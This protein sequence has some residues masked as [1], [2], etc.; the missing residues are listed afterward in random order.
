MTHPLL[1]RVRSL[2]NPIG[3]LD[4]R[5]AT[6]WRRLIRRH[7][8]L[9]ALAVNT[10]DLGSMYTVAGAAGLLAALGRRRDAADLAIVGTAAWFIGQESKRVFNRRR[11]FEADPAL[12]RLIKPPTGSSFPSG[13]ATV[14]AAM[15]TLMTRRSAGGRRW[16]WTAIAVWVPLTRIHVG[17]HS[18]GDTA[19]GAVLGWSIARSV[20]RLVTTTRD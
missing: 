2:V 19:A 16:P 4:V 20:E 8:A 5:L 12:E 18:P 14:A 10:T 7:P 9:D 13:H 1:R 17:V 3:P 11:P 15:A 6:A